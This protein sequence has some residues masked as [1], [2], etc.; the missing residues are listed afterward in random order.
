MVALEEGEVPIKKEEQAYGQR[1][2]N[3]VQ[4]VGDNAYNI[5][6]PGEMNIST[7]FSVGDSLPTLR[8]KMRAMNI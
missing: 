1:S 5:E 8:M 7:T 2:Y 4:K 3:I 6:L